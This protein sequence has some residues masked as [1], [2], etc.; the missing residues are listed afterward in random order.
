[1]E[2]NENFKE[3]FMKNCEKH[4]NISLIS[5]EV[6]R[7]EDMNMFQNDQFDYVFTSHVLCSVGD[8]KKSLDE[9]HRV[10]KKVIK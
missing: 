3:F 4:K 5:Y 1:M 2:Y 7:M 6:G 10:L 8:V 9:V